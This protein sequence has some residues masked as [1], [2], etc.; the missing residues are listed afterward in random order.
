VGPFVGHHQ[1]LQALSVGA[2]IEDKV[3]GPDLMN[4]DQIQE[5]VETAKG[6]AA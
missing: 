1:A 5:Y 2:A 4:F 3:V 6:V